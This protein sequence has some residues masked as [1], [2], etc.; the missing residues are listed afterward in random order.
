MRPDHPQ[1]SWPAVLIDWCVIKALE[2][3]GCPDCLRHKPRLLPPL[4]S[5]LSA[6]LRLKIH[7][8]RLGEIAALLDSAAESAYAHALGE[9]DRDLRAAA[10]DAH[11]DY[12][13]HYDDTYYRHR[14]DVRLADVRLHLLQ[15]ERLSPVHPGPTADVRPDRPMT[16]EDDWRRHALLRD[17]L[18]AAD[19]AALGEELRCC[20]D[21]IAATDALRARAERLRADLSSLRAPHVASAQ[22]ARRRAARAFWGKL[23]SEWFD[24]TVFADSPADSVESS[25]ARIDG[26]WWWRRFIPALQ[27]RF[28]RG[29]P[30][31]CFLHEQMPLLRTLATQPGQKFVLSG[32]VEQWREQH[33]ADHFGLGAPV[34]QPMLAKRA[35]DKATV[36]ADWLNDRLPGYTTDAGLRHA[37]QRSLAS[38]LAALDPHPI[39]PGP[40]SSQTGE[41]WRN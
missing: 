14:A 12:L 25:L 1:S 23:V 6:A 2:D 9:A 35:R 21:L 32:V 36:V 30:N 31:E 4:V 5:A 16:A 29:Q 20:H 13:A 11:R 33:G 10:A 17:H 19:H 8:D 34:H 7:F 24:E 39:K 26:P 18:P 3:A 41:H 15:S 38:H 27:K 37:G 28:H 40:S 22:A